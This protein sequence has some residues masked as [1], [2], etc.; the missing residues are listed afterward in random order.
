M[1]ASTEP[2]AERCAT[3]HDASASARRI[4][5]ADPSTQSS[6]VAAT[7]SMMVRTPRPS[8]PSRCAQVPSSSSSE[9]AFER[10]PSL[11]LRRTTSSRFRVPSGRTR[12]TRKQVTPPGAWASTRNTSFIGAEVNHLCPKSSYSPSTDVATADVTLARTSEPPCF[13]VMPM[14]ASAPALSA[15]GRT[16]KS[17]VVDASFGVHSLASA[18][19]TRRAGTAAYVMEIGHPCPGSVC[20]Q[21]MKPAA[22]RTWA[23]GSSEVQGVAPSPKPTPR[24][25]SQCHDGWKRTSSTRLPNRS[26][27][28]SSGWWR[29]AS[30]PCS[31]PSSLPARRPR[32][33][34][35]EATVAEA[36]RVTASTSAMSEVTTS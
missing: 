17:Y 15:T 5:D 9:D 22:R 16:P 19:S 33:E 7:I 12:G 24:S 21:A 32:G 13:S 30:I 1:S 31:R 36:C 23:C 27:P 18:S 10:L 20:D 8:S 25:I 14:P 6:R 3:C 29:F 2:N 4:S 28:T 11:S 34:R 26:K 35:S